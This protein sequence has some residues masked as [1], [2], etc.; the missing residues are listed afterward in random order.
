MS[1]LMTLSYII[2][3]KFR[4]KCLLIRLELFFILLS[5]LFLTRIHCWTSGIYPKLPS[6]EPTCDNVEC[7]HG[8]CLGSICHCDFGWQGISCD[9]C[10]GRIR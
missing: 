7:L 2:K 3:A 8:Y 6:P 10:G 5:I 9:R 4:R 1:S